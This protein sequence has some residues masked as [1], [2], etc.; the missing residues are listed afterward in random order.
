MSEIQI[1]LRLRLIEIPW[2]RSKGENIVY[3]S[4]K[5]KVEIE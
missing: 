5:I 2:E 3:R 4:S 1:R